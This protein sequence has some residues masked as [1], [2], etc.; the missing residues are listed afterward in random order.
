MPLNED[1]EKRLKAEVMEA[2]YGPSVH[3]STEEK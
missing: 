2:F 1:E 3:S